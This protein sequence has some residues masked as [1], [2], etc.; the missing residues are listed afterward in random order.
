MIQ[1]STLYKFPSNNKV[2]TTGYPLT[3]YYRDLSEVLSGV[4]ASLRMPNEKVYFFKGTKVWLWGSDR[5]PRLIRE[6]WKGVPNSIDAAFY[7]QENKKVYFFKKEYFYRYFRKLSSDT[8]KLQAI[9]FA[10]RNKLSLI[11]TCSQGP[12][13]RERGPWLPLFSE[14]NIF[15]SRMYTTNRRAPTLALPPPP[16]SKSMHDPRF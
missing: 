13:T 16:L 10:Y 1:D 11:V 7:W 5:S 9:L 2:L 14:N 15:A 3:L 12:R 8:P 4:D 6:E